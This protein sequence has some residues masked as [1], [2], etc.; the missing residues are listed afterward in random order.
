MYNTDLQ[1]KCIRIGFQGKVIAYITVKAQKQADSG[2]AVLQANILP[3]HKHP[4]LASSI[5]PKQN[6]ADS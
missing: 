2:R 1:S 5:N 3:D 4:S 6:N